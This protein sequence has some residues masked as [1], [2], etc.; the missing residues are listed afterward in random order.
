MRSRPRA[1]AS[2]VE[3]LVVVC[4]LAVLSGLLL[5][6]VQRARESAR[7]MACSSNLKNLGLA[8]QRHHEAKR[9][10]PPGW[11]DYPA[12]PSGRAGVAWGS[13]LLP[14][15][16]EES[17]WRDW[18]LNAQSYAEDNDKARQ[19]PL[20]LFRCPSDI[21]EFSFDVVRPGA[22]SNITRV[23]RSNYTAT[24][25]VAGL[26]R[27]GQPPSDTRLFP[28]LNVRQITDGLSQT[29]LCGETATTKTDH[30]TWAEVWGVYLLPPDA[31]ADYGGISGPHCHT[32]VAGRMMPSDGNWDTEPAF[33]HRDFDGFSSRHPQGV[34]F[35]F[36]DGHV[37]FLPN[38][39]ATAAKV[40]LETID[41]GDKPSYD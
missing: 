11:A 36:A 32:F 16:E 23:S 22:T 5:S 20:A 33:G 41:G 10:F 30:R 9:A 29:V 39:L 18:Q 15:L 3:L 24:Y 13:M 4:I 19:T 6:A 27:A 38:A 37:A 25:A 12:G 7:R 8:F 2:L 28:P 14:Y 17:L 40:A 1:G 26:E 21:G 35:A 31:P 34:N